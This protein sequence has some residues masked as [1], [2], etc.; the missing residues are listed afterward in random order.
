MLPATPG[1]DRETARQFLHVSPRYAPQFGGAG[2]SLN[3]RM[4]FEKGYRLTQRLSTASLS[5]TPGEPLLPKWIS[6]H[7]AVVVE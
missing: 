4:T 5:A 7:R 1:C 2:A 3:F 6:D